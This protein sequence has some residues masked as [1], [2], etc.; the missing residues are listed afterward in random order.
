AKLKEYVESLVKRADDIRTKV[1]SDPRV[2]NMLK[3]TTDGRKAATDLRLVDIDE[4]H[5]GSK[6][7][8]AVENIEKVW[9]ETA[10]TKGTQLVF[11]DMGTPNGTRW[12]LY[13]DM[14]AKLVARGIPEQ[15]IAFIHDANTDKQ[16]ETL[17]QAVRDGKVRVL[18]G[19]TEK[20]G[21]GTN[22]QT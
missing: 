1:V 2:D 10:D 9:Q 12:S 17:F 16:K 21:M 18:F 5:P 13:G 19:S 20:M 6:T 7:N 8:L 4:D 22:V 11:L 14:K 15:E 3:V